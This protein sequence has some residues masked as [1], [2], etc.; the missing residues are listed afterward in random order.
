MSPAEIKVLLADDHFMV[1]LGLASLIGR[2]PDLRVV[3]EAG[4]GAEALAAC[5]DHRPDVVLMDIRMPEEDGVAATEAI[6]KRC[7]ASKVIVL[8]SYE[9]DEDIHRALSAGAKAY[10]LKSVAGETLLQGIRAVHSGAYCLPADVSAKLAR[11]F[12]CR[13][14]TPREREILAR[15]ADGR[16]NKEIAAQLS[17]AESTVKNHVR[18][19]LEKLGARDRT[20]AVTRA[21]ERGIIHLG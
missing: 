5:L 21:I 15:L 12:S 14:L 8:T 17:V 6:V 1:R 16:S 2:E 18:L 3:A 13:Q 4:T 20:Q 11:W 19:I 10:F 9:G 7:P